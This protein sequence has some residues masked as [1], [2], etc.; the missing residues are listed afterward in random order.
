MK[1]DDLRATDPQAWRG[2]RTWSDSGTVEAVVHHHAVAQR[3]GQ[4]LCWITL[5]AMCAA[6]CGC[7][8][9]RGHRAQAPTFVG[10]CKLSRTAQSEGGN[11]LQA[12]VGG[13]VV[14]HQNTTS[15]GLF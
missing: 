9:H 3:E 14:V 2:C 6:N 10:D 13:V 7:P 12:E 11:H 4:S 15:G 1:G 8:Y 5:W